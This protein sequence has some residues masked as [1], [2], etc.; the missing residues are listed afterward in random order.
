MSKSEF[1]FPVHPTVPEV[2]NPE[3]ALGTLWAFVEGIGVDPKAIIDAYATADAFWL[4]LGVRCLLS[5]SAPVE[6]RGTFAIDS[7]SK[8]TRDDVRTIYAVFIELYEHLDMSLRS[9]PLPENMEE[10]QE[11]KARVA[12]IINRICSVEPGPAWLKI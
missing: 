2:D 11:E 4:G 7:C 3:Q 8:L 12:A 1:V 9:L 6:A 10:V 5:A